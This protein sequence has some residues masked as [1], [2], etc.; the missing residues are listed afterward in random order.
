MAFVV[1]WRL[2]MRSAI[3]ARNASFASGRPRSGKCTLLLSKLKWLGVECFSMSSIGRKI[4]RLCPLRMMLGG[5]R[6]PFPKAPIGNPGRALR[7]PALSVSNQ[8][9]KSE[10]VGPFNNHVVR[11]CKLGLEHTAYTPP[12]KGAK[13]S[14]TAETLRAVPHHEK[15]S[16]TLSIAGCCLFFTLIQSG[17]RVARV[18]ANNSA[19]ACVNDR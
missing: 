5:S 12:V 8:Y 19:P 9:D 18:Q 3:S 6:T 7:W 17:Q 1:P 14:E 2:M 4:R 15:A 16:L 13:Q 11:K 10:R